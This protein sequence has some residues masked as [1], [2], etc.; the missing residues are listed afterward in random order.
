VLIWTKHV[1][2]GA[3]VSPYL[4]QI[5]I[6]TRVPCHTNQLPQWNFILKL[7]KLTVSDALDPSLYLEMAPSK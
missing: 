6:K 1:N 5:N 2:A 3:T 7:V 4:S